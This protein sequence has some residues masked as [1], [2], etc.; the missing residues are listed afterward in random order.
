MPD[1]VTRREAKAAGL[2]RYFSGTLCHQHHVSQRYTSNGGCI[3]CNALY[4][5]ECIERYRNKKVRAGVAPVGVKKD[6]SHLTVAQI[7]EWYAHVERC[8]RGPRPLVQYRH[9][10]LQ[11]RAVIFTAP[12]TNFG[13]N[14]S[15]DRD[16]ISQRI[17]K[18]R[19][20]DT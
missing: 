5:R 3:E 7:E 9:H 10:P 19:A 18:M 12:P 2:D 14:P 15:I 6:W 13:R 11:D 17:A 1:I 4:E 20:R 8:R 16:L